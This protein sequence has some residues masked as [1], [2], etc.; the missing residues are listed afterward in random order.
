MLWLVLGIVAANIATAATVAELRCEHLTNPA[1]LDDSHPALSWIIASDRRSETQTAYQVLVASTEEL[2]AADKGD[3]WDSGKVLSPESAQIEYAGQ[4]LPS[5]TSG[6]WKVRIWDRDG[7]PSAWSQSASWSMGLLNPADWTAQWISDPI[8][9]D[10]ANRP[11]TPIHCYR[12]ELASSS[13]AGKWIVLDFGSVKRMDAVD[14]IPARPRA[15]IVIFAR[16]CFRFVSKWRRRTIGISAMR[17]S[18]WT[19]PAKIFRTRATIRVVSNSRRSR[20]V[21]FVSRHPAGPLGWSELRR[22][23][24]RLVGL[25]WPDDRSPLGRA[26]NA[27]IPSNPNAG[28]K[29]FWWTAKRR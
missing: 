26:W 27:R 8:L 5:R 9:A 6:F 20:R 10:P 22:R 14:I 7:K 2:L 24:G 28:P 19:I 3:L 16:R 18:W 21:M 23:F 4:T 1:G 13:E 15:R 17:N 29:N 11:L 12:S 25:R